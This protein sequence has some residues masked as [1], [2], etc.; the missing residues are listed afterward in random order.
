[1]LTLSGG[2]LAE[3][4]G[5]TLV[6]G[7]AD[8]MVNGVCIDSRSIDAGAAFLAIRGQRSDGHAFA[9]DALRAGARA[10]VVTDW[11]DAVRAAVEE[12]GRRDTSVVRVDDAL[13][14]VTALARY[15]RSR[16]S[17]P[18]VGVTGSTGKTTTKDFLVGA[19]GTKLRVTATRANR[20][21]ELG[22]PLTVLEAGSE[23][24][25]LVVEMGMRGAGQIAALCEV[26]RPTLGLVTNIG[27]THIELLGTQEAILHAKGELVGCIPA[28]GAVFLNGDDAWS[29]RLSGE[30]A[31]PVTYYGL[32]EASDVRATDIVLGDDGRPTLTLLAGGEAVTLTLPLP[33][34]HNAYNAAAA[35]AVALR[36]GVGLTDIAEGLAHVELTEWRMQ[37]FTAA[38]GVTVVNDAYN[39]NPT[40]M[41]AAID[42]LSGMRPEGRRIAVLGD[43]RELG[44]L[45]ELAHFRLGEQI[46]RAPIDVLVTVGDLGRRIAEGAQAEGMDA[47]AVRACAGAEEAS[48][49]LDDLLAPGDAVLVKAS[50]SMGLERVVEGIVHPRA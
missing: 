13:A 47:A 11:S 15:H 28:D 49:V 36:L 38:N 7:S 33:G 14:A 34:R 5:G 19:L 48:E 32:V 8:A 25:V 23:S 42:T 39:A 6:A 24:D 1:M 37:V 10:L 45:A 41:R 43:M 20:N 18:V 26:A 40:S 4:T 16:L 29:R 2:R 21:N 22:V 31:A 27:Q 17:C 9:A 46:A 12:S 50:R 30:S 44:S 3:V 35:A